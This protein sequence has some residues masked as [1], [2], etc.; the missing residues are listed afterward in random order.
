MT[1]GIGTGQASY[2]LVVVE[3][4]SLVVQHEPPG[5]SSNGGT[6]HIYWGTKD[7]QQ[8]AHVTTTAG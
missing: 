8:S 5:G 2:Q 4:R 3:A 6:A 1:R 7:S